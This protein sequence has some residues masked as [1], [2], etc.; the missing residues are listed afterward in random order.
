[1]S[2]SSHEEIQAWGGRRDHR[3][4]AGGKS[5]VEMWTQMRWEAHRRC[6]ALADLAHRNRAC[7]AAVFSASSQPSRTCMRGAATARRVVP[8]APQFVMA[9]PESPTAHFGRHSFRTR[10]TAEPLKG[11]GDMRTIV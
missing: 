9:R 8:N 5:W 11:F 2:G 4:Q 1:M 3:S 6:V 7:P 10:I